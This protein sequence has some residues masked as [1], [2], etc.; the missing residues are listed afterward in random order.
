[1]DALFGAARVRALEGALAAAARSDAPAPSLKLALRLLE[2]PTQFHESQERAPTGERLPYGPPERWPCT[3]RRCFQLVFMAAAD[4]LQ[5]AVIVALLRTVTAD[6]AL[7][8]DWSACLLQCLACAIALDDVQ[9]VRALLDRQPRLVEHILH[10][11]HRVWVDA[12]TAFNCFGVHLAHVVLDSG[13]FTAD[14]TSDGC[15]YDVFSMALCNTTPFMYAVLVGAS[16][17]LLE[18]LSPLS[19]PASYCTG[20][21]VQHALDSVDFHIVSAVAAAGF[22]ATDLT[23]PKSINAAANARAIMARRERQQ[24]QQ[25][26]QPQH[27]PQQPRDVISSRPPPNFA[28]TFWPCAAYAGEAPPFIFGCGRMTGHFL[29]YHASA[30]AL[31]RHRAAAQAEQAAAQAAQ[32]R[33]AKEAQA[34]RERAAKEQAERKAAAARSALLKKAGPLPLAL[35]GDFYAYPVDVGLRIGY[36]FGTDARGRA[37]CCFSKS[38][39]VEHSLEAVLPL[40]NAMRNAILD[41][42]MHAL[43]R[44]LDALSTHCTE[45]THCSNCGVAGHRAAQ[46]KADPS[47]TL[48][49][50]EGMWNN[51]YWDAAAVWGDVEAVRCLEAA[52]KRCADVD[53]L[54]WA[55]LH[56]GKDELLLVAL[57]KKFWAVACEAVAALLAYKGAAR[58]IART[59]AVAALT[60]AGGVTGALQLAMQLSAPAEVLHDLWRLAE[61][62]GVQAQ[63]LTG[64]SSPGPGP[65]RQSPLLHH[66][67]WTDDAALVELVVSWHRSSAVSADVIPLHPPFVPGRVGGEPHRAQEE[68]E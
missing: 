11:V 44:A 33:A 41:K 26:R 2:K 7:P 52:L 64:E 12:D 47:E 63:L 58:D 60:P 17:A 3:V 1:M 27:Q 6:M 31:Q 56:A 46:C 67:V 38:L 55:S 19:I 68:E 49:K 29:G 9:C 5:A 65:G 21:C 53:L 66:A 8:E 15:E 20:V 30:A 16:N 59:G 50:A 57:R 39:Y 22:V 45:R 36:K 10:D 24:Q 42:D 37:G 48:R 25:Q 61:M 40:Y 13:A 62:A 14:S 51:A 35:T 34:A 32:E 54:S 43:Q 28:E 23:R 18:L 4:Q